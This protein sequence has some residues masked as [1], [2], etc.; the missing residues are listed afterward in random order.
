MVCKE[1]LR[2]QSTDSLRLSVD[3]LEIN[4]MRHSTKL[5]WKLNSKL[6]SLFSVNSIPN[7]EIKSTDSAIL[8]P[9]QEIDQTR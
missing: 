3:I 8:L 5:N 1:S 2:S 7:P 6:N 4:T 9:R